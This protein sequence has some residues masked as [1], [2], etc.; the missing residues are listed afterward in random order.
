MPDQLEPFIHKLKDV[1]GLDE[2]G[3]QTLRVLPFRSIRMDKGEQL[4][5]TGAEGLPC[6]VLIEG[7]VSRYKLRKD[8]SAAITAFELSGDIVNLESLLLN[9][10][11]CG[12]RVNGPSS[13]A[14][15]EQEAISRARLTS[16]SLEVA[17]WRYALVKA[18]ALEEWLLNIGRR[19][20]TGRLAHLLSELHVRLV[21]VGSSES[22]A[23][24]LHASPL[25]LAE[26]MGLQQIIVTRCLHELASRRVITLTDGTIV[27]RDAEGLAKLGDFQ[28][29]YLHI[30]PG[31]RHAP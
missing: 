8:D 7:C 15:I 4:Y 1:A 28:S 19:S 24:T 18:A 2:D 3:A 30:A 14:V 6:Y 5:A 22:Y 17:L 26:A 27:I 13:I 31:G 20:P 29:S 11:D 9:R 16:R 10:T 23:F 21:S 12:A 25:D